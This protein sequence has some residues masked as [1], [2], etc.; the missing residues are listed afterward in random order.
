MASLRDLGLSEYE[1]RAYRSLLDTGPTTAKELSRTSDVPM[2]RIYD[3]L[4]SLETQ[5]LARSQ[6]ASRPKKYV[7][8]E[9]EAALDR[10]LEDKEQELEEQLSQFESI[11]SELETQLEASD[12]VDEQFWT[13]ALGAEETIDL[14]VER[15]AAADERIIFVAATPTSRFDVDAVGE[16]ITDELERVLERGI[17]VSLLEHPAVVET[18]PTEVG[19]RYREH[20]QDYDHFEVRVVEDIGSTFAIIDHVEICIEVPHPLNRKEAFALINLKDAEFA[21]DVESTFE[22]RWEQARD[23]SLS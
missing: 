3:V 23:F 1:S 20:L 5:N 19:E 10:L 7:A 18:L 11:A 16:R 8:V 21:A 14:L 17:P 6:A 22:T 4:N 12:P 13:A 2:G 9:P 15:L